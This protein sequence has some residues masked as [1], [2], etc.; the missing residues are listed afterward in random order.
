MC[1]VAHYYFDRGADITPEFLKSK[2]ITA[3]LLDIDNTLTLFHN[4]RLYSHREERWLEELK[5]GGIK[6]CILSNN[7]NKKRIEAFARMVGLPYVIKARKPLP[8][9]ALEACR[10]LGCEPCQTAVV[11]DQIFTDIACA[12][13]SGCTGIL[14]GYFEKEKSLFFDIKRFLEKPFVYLSRKRRI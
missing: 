9:G 11:G 5:N 14:V 10:L 2:G 12:R 8:K 4:P 13:L 1:L 3:L 6:V 7:S